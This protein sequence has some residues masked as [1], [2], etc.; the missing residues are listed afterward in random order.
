MTKR[1]TR[2]DFELFISKTSLAARSG[3]LRRPSVTTTTRPAPPTPNSYV[4]PTLPSHAH[5]YITPAL[6]TTHAHRRHDT[7]AL[8]DGSLEVVVLPIADLEGRVTNIASAIVVYIRLVGVRVIWTV[9]HAV[10]DGVSIAIN[11]DIE[12]R[13][14]LA[15][16]H[17]AFQRSRPAKGVGHR[18]RA[19]LRAA[20]R[21]H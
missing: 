10:P 20:H 2:S 15:S 4:A 12:R 8:V 16:T 3:A 19:G 5:A 14:I 1:D 18:G 6:T 9:V 21:I 11:H 13:R 17:P 7:R